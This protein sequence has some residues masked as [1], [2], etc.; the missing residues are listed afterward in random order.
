[1]SQQKTT[2]KT[3]TA[4]FSVALM[5]FLG[6]LNETS[7]NV[8]YPELS[9]TFGISLD[10]T[11]WIT[12]GYLLMVTIVMGTTAYL[13]RQ[14]PAKRIHLFCVTAFIVGDIVCA[15]APSLLCCW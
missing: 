11:Q 2:A 14:Y 6:V 15:L 4:I 9:R 1:M 10:I 12:A 8:T 5:T 3:Y 7:M 13:L